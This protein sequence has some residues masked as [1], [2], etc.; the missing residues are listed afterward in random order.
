MTIIG[1]IIILSVLMVFDF[2]GGNISSSGYIENNIEY[3]DNYILVLNKN[4]ISNKGYVPLGRLLYFFYEN[5]ELSFDEIYDLNL[6]IETK[7]LK[8]ISDVCNKSFNGY[9]VCKESAII[10]SNQ[11]DEYTYKPF[12]APVDFSKV[13][14]T[15]FFGQERVVYDEFDIHYAWDLAGEAETPIYSVGDGIVKE[16]RFNQST[17]EIKKDNGAG[18]YIV[19]EYE[20]NDEKVEV[21]YGH[22]FP[23]SNKVKVG[24]HVESWQTIAT[25]GTTGYS[26]GN[27]LHYQV[28]FNGSPIDGMNLLD[29]LN[30]KNI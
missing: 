2:F 29:F 13:S 20:V 22:L 27:H 11:D 6:D 16:V 5:E 28:T 15:S 19:I 3:A 10:D 21:L 18:N 9:F 23:N 26:T 7:R 8:P 25:M 12:N 17:N 30:E 4:I 1:M 14:I 24:D